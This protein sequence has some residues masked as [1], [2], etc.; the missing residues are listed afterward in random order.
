MRILSVGIVR[1]SDDSCNNA[2]HYGGGDI[3]AKAAAGFQMYAA[4]GRAASFV[5][6]VL[7]GAS[8][9]GDRGRRG[10]GRGGSREYEVFE[11]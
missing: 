4:S 11:I 1:A 9:S 10:G 6:R 8:S 5:R 2:E 3:R 7:A